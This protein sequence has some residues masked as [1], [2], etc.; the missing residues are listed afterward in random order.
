LKRI[1]S[2]DEELALNKLKGKL[3]NN[4]KKSKLVKDQINANKSN[5]NINNNV[6]ILDSNDFKLEESNY[7]SS[8]SSLN[9]KK[10][11]QI[12]SDYGI[13][14]KLAASAASAAAVTDQ[15]AV[16]LPTLDN[17][18]EYNNCEDNYNSYQNYCQNY[19]YQQQ[20]QQQQQQHQ[21]QHIQYDSQYNNSY[22]QQMNQDQSFYYNNNNHHHHHHSQ[23]PFIYTQEN[24]D[25]QQTTNSY[26]YNSTNFSIH[27]QY[28][29]NNSISSTGSSSSCNLQEANPTSYLSSLSSCSS[30]SCSSTTSSISNTISPIPANYNSFNESIL[31]NN[32]NNN[33]SFQFASA[34]NSA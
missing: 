14:M 20:Q 24:I 30:S 32:I 3:I 27:S 6:R 22:S 21:Q 28:A 4:L 12:H 29:N 18:Y 8:S 1:C 2:T 7:Y 34:Y 5:K 11:K 9:T 15:S 13:E 25:Q 31:N 23:T 16:V 17:T 33:N 26:P 10:T 19:Y